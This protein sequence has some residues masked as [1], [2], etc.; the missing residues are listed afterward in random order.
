MKAGN[1]VAAASDQP[2]PGSAQ[3]RQ[4]QRDGGLPKRGMPV[5]G[6]VDRE[7]GHV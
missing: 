2:R 4:R 3:R 6:G 7:A 1:S 5:L